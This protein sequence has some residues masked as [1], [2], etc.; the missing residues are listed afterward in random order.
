MALAS[1]R[2]GDG[3][4]QATKKNRSLRRNRHRMPLAVGAIL[5][6][7]LDDL[8]PQSR[9]WCT[10]VEHHAAVRASHDPKACE[11]HSKIDGDSSARPLRV[12]LRK[13]IR[14]GRC[15]AN[16]HQFLRLPACTVPATFPVHCP[17]RI[18]QHRSPAGSLVDSDL[19]EQPE[20]R[21]APVQPAPSAGIVH[22]AF[23]WSRH[24]T[25][26]AEQ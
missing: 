19:G 24:S 2:S 4:L 12:E 11:Q 9:E 14:S 3:R 21:A 18:A 7:E 8:A 22:A 25:R 6:S 1:S 20:R 15:I 5:P 23:V 13:E 26:H 16:V 17:H 10:F